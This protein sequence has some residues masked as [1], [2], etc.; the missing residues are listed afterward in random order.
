MHVFSI[1]GPRFPRVLDTDD[2]PLAAAL[3]FAAGRRTFV[4]DAALARPSSSASSSEYALL[5]LL[6]PLRTLAVRLR[7]RAAAAAATIAAFD[8]ATAAA[9]R[10]PPDGAF[11]PGAF[12]AGFAGSALPLNDAL[13]VESGSDSSLIASTLGFL[14]AA[15]PFPEAASA[16]SCRSSASC[17]CSLRTVSSF[18]FSG[19]FFAATFFVRFGRPSI[20]SKPS[21]STSSS[22]GRMPFRWPSMVGPHTRYMANTAFTAASRTSP[23]ACPSIVRRD[24]I[25]S[26]TDSPASSS[27][28]PSS[29]FSSA[30]S[31]PRRIRAASGFFALPMRFATT[32]GFSAGRDASC[33]TASSAASRVRGVMSPVRRMRSGSMRSAPALSSALDARGSLVSAASSSSA[34]RNTCAILSPIPRTHRLMAARNTAPRS[35]V[36]VWSGSRISAMAFSNARSR[37]A[38]TFECARAARSLPKISTMSAISR[39]CFSVS[40]SGASDA[41]V[42]VLPSSSSAAPARGPRGDTAAS[43]D[44]LGSGRSS[45]GSCR[46]FV[47]LGDARGD[48]FAPSPPDFRSRRGDGGARGGDVAASPSPSAALRR[49]TE[50]LGSSSSAAPGPRRTFSGRSSFGSDRRTGCALSA[51][52]GTATRDEVVVAGTSCWS[53]GT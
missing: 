2:R 31:L 35:I 45:F 6:A 15:P 47:G 33:T 5:R 51:S 7:A 52:S 38:H 9:A 48:A 37:C 19:S 8:G 46:P 20:A 42:R 21:F 40:S 1:A 44:F 12:P 30:S 32:T 23:L 4:D 22:C 50:P 14:A 24:F 39:S 25:A 29:S 49:S 53:R 3:A 43:L 11:A 26:A 27:R 16:A 17:S 36:S 28:P 10:D 18:S 41:P 34:L 13:G